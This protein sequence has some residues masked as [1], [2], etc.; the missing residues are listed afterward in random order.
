MGLGERA[1]KK[2]LQT[3]EHR[4]RIQ[5]ASRSKL[6]I[7]EKHKDYTIRARDYHK[8]Q[9]QLKG[10]RLRAANRNPDEYYFGMVK[11]RL[12][13]G[14]HVKDVIEGTKSIPAP[15]LKLMKSQDA[16]Y[17]SV[18][19]T[20]NAKRL[21]SLEE[22]VAI[23][24]CMSGGAHNAA[25]RQHIIF[26]VDIEEQTLLVHEKRATREEEAVGKPALDMLEELDETPAEK[27]A[28]RKRQELEA[29]RERVRQLEKVEHKLRL[30]R[31]LLGTGK[32]TKIGTDEYGFAK[33][34]W[35]VER[36]K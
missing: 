4:E 6:G 20:A 9:D 7:L 19:R 23:A 5:P 10:L 31:H 35:A 26:A 30:D 27:H 15:M 14:R 34:K 18:Q 2:A 21:A 29:R 8:K 28:S 25:P 22:E 36:K 13:D 12:V 16:A 24:E 1:F 33:Y 11:S 32:R 3:G 17:I